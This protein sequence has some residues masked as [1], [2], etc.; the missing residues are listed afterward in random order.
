MI[1]E[2]VSEEK[3]T[4]FLDQFSEEVWR[5]T[6]KDH[7]DLTIND[8]F[9]RVAK[10]LASVEKE[11]VKEEW[12][13]KFYDLLTDFKFLAGGRTYSNAGTEWKGT[14]LHNCFSSETTVLTKDGTEKISNLIGKTVQVLNCNRKWVDTVFKSFGKQHL[15]KITLSNGD[16]IFATEKHNWKVKTGRKNVFANCDT[17]NLKGKQL[18]YISAILDDC[19]KGFEFKTGVQHGLVYG[20]GTLYLNGKYS[21]LNQFGDSCHLV[22]DWFEN[23]VEQKGYSSKVK[24]LC[25]GKLNPE[26]KTSIPTKF[27]K[28]EYILGFLAGIVA[29]DG[30]VDKYGSVS[31]FQSDLEFLKE[32]RSL[33]NHCGIVV[34]SIKMYREKS[35]FTG[36]IS[37]CYKLAFLKSSFPNFLILKKK[38]LELR[39]K[40]ISKIDLSVKVVSI[41]KTDRYEEVYCCEEPITN[42]FVLG[43]LILT[44][45]CFVGT[46]SEQDQDSLEGIFSTLLAQA[47]TLKSE[48]GWGMNFSFIRP[49]GAF[50]YGIGVETPGAVKYMEIF[51]KSS[52]IITAGSGKKS[53]NKKAKGKIRK[54]AQMGVLSVWHPDIE[55]FIT[56]KLNEGRLSKF[57]LSV[58]CSNEFMDKI[59]EIQD[60]LRNNQDIP[61]ELDQWNL[62]FPD[63][64]FTKY[65]TE[66][67]GNINKWKE[68]NYPI[69][70]YKTISA[71]G[72]W[73]K[74]MES[75]YSR[76]DPGVLFMDRANETHCW[77]YGKNS[78]ISATNPCQ[79]DWATVLTK[80]GIRELKDISIGDEIWSETGWTKI[81]NKWST[82]IK[83]VYKYGTTAGC[84]Y[85]TENHRLISNG[86]KIE[87]KDCESVDRLIGKY[88]SNILLNTQDIMDGLVF[89]D[90]SVHKASNNLVY[91]C[92]GEKDQDY[93]NSEIKELL[94]KD[95]PGLHH[96]A[97][98][99]KT[100]ISSDEIPLTY[101]RKIPDRFIQGSRDKVCGFLR[102]LFTANGSMCADRVTL[103][104]SSFEVIEDTQIMLS[105]IGIR[106]YFTSNTGQ[107]IKFSNGEYRCRNS[108]TLN[109]TTDRNKFAQSIGFI[110]KYKTEK[111][112]NI[113]QKIGRSERSLKQS[114][115]VISVDLISE[116]EVFN[117]TVD[118]NS[119]T[120]WTGGLNV[121]NCGEQ[122]LPN[123]SI[124]T[125]GTIN[126]TQFIDFKNNKFDLEKIK[127][128]VSYGVRFLDNV[129]SL[130]VAP[131]KE[132]E[133]SMR[134]RRRIGLG[135]MGWAS[136][137]YIL[138]IKFAS[139]QAKKIQYDLMKTFTHAGVDAS[140]SLAKEKGMFRDCEPIKHSLSPY[141]K[142][143]ELPQEKI[144]EIAEYGIRNSALF[145]CQPN[146]NTSIFANIVS[147]GIEPEFL[148]EYTRTV[149]LPECP[150]FLKNKCP[151]Y[152]EGDYEENEFFASRKEGNDNIL[153]YVYEDGTVYKIDKNRGLTKEV[154][155]ESY[156]V[157]YLKSINSW[158]PNADWA[159]TANSLSVQEHI[160]DMTGFAKWMD[161]AI[162]KT[163]NIPNDY[164][165]D[166]FKSLYLNAY[167]SKYLKGITT[168]RAGTMTTVL[169]EKASDVE[170]EEK[171]DSFKKRNKEL[172]SDIYHCK[173]KNYE[174][175]CIVGLNSC[176]NPYEIFAGK[177]GVISKHIE[178]GIVYKVKKGYYQLLDTETKEVILDN[179][180]SLLTEDGEALTRMISMSLRHQVNLEY[181]VDQLIKVEGDLTS[182]SKVM[183]RCLKKY[184][185]DGTKMSQECPS[186]KEKTV[187]YTNGCK[188]CNSCGWTA[189]Q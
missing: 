129:N 138:N 120:Y 169:S 106:S 158:K 59:V 66:W 77:N 103:K 126:L 72:L 37:P 26:F 174:Y 3:T 101:L 159:V 149:I 173:V 2:T 41:I 150:D 123:G 102:G 56:A 6:Y 12:E 135:V 73:N 134:F 177:N 83:K 184:I 85:G 164:N 186:C 144:N 38:H 161:A 84:F 13:D 33:A 116:E 140:L 175:F 65:K 7:K 40:N 165:Y 58:D 162:S 79:P 45:N 187:I 68:K 143:I 71:Q 136:A 89:G 34:T 110:Q 86:E 15:Y 39:K 147:G 104:A 108:F 117:I 20:D 111:L 176:G 146:G 51:D 32:I 96:G 107:N 115:Q 156:G 112:E 157:R 172:L 49:R 189:C 62:I 16:D 151:K 87:A 154:P 88:Q 43:N 113:I 19:S 53:S 182:L 55:E 67:D 17:L 128:Y 130:S 23:F 31:L 52:D 28:K 74:I 93:F 155:C 141:W 95:R 166:D 124:C 183:A 46:K 125:L 75:T 22:E 54:G 168:Y 98:E 69:V 81:I 82:G 18:P 64:T 63:T 92:I 105:S 131:L 29:A 167:K 100:T 119:H 180:T 48:G 179:L 47:K 5:N 171:C 60:L 118:N 90:G 142:Q 27:N 148:H 91:L 185:I 1:K 160:D 11:E 8:T 132:Y 44:G 139:K 137:L 25:V 170:K 153:R 109:I 24:H 10:A 122:P 163:V 42:T 80:N 57:N 21:R 114:Y 70:V 133:D 30:C 145:S 178:K 99:I 78:H 4:K 9:R 50:I 97:Y 35:P 188:Q 121:S 61:A 36:E 181:V 127:K 152:W 76:N 94:I 14:T